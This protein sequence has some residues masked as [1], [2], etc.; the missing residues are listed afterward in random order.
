LANQIPSISSNSIWSTNKPESAGIGLNHRESGGFSSGIG[1]ESD[2][3]SM[4]STSP[5]LKV[6]WPIQSNYAKQQQQQAAAAV[7]LQQQAALAATLKQQQQQQQAALQQA[8]HGKKSAQSCSP[9][10]PIGSNP[11]RFVSQQS[12]HLNVKPASSNPPQLPKTQKYVPPNKKQFNLKNANTNSNKTNEQ[13]K[14]GPYN[15]VLIVGLSQEYRSLN[16]VL[17]IFRPY[18]DV[19]SARVYRPYSTLPNEITRWCP[20]VEVQDSFAAV[21]EYPTAR[22]AKFAVG[23]LRERVQANKYRVVLLKPGAYEELQRQKML[24]LSAEN[25]KKSEKTTNPE[26]DSGNESLEVLSS[27]NSDCTSD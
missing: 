6:L 23:V 3:S 26:S 18:G 24:I 21:V 27:R 20:S 17:N 10:L 2:T 9:I 12:I 16:G 14:Q 4:R 25:E 19:V 5:D 7:K 8:A 15:K 11:G 13:N 22:C 1:S